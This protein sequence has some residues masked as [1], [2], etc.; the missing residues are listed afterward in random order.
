MIRGPC[1]P[2]WAPIPEYT[3]CTHQ[4][5]G[6]AGDTARPR[7]PW[8]AE[9]GDPEVL[10]QR[11][12]LRLVIQPHPRRP[13]VDAITARR[14]GSEKREDGGK[15]SVANAAAKPGRVRFEEDVVDTPRLEPRRYHEA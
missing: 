15:V 1:L 10:E 13:H 12:H 8:L 6:P 3:H 14:R 2:S 5:V 11:G 7:V 4:G 9:R